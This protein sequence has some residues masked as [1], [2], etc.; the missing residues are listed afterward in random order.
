M[1]LVVPVRL[2]SIERYIV[3]KHGSARQL[4][5][6]ELRILQQYGERIVELIQANWPVDTGYSRASWVV[7]TKVKP[8]QVAFEVQ[9]DAPYVQYVHLMGTPAQPPLWQT[10]VP[11][12]VQAVAPGL[13]VALRAQIDKTEAELSQTG[14][15]F[16]DRI[17]SQRPSAFRP[18]PPGAA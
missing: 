7:V 12:V 11:R 2:E 17:R 9:N 13:L 1:S 4:D 5:T 15:T 14:M 10:L 3:Q 16:L 8:G 18:Q 6:A